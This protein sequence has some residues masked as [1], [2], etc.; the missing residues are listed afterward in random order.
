MVETTDVHFQVPY[1]VPS[2]QEVASEIGQDVQTPQF[3]AEQQQQNVVLSTVVDPLVDDDAEQQSAQ[4]GDRQRNDD[5]DD[6]VHEV[7]TQMRRGFS[8]FLGYRRT[9]SDPELSRPPD[10]CGDEYCAVLDA[11]PEHDSGVNECAARD[12][13]SPRW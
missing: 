1:S 8:R 9:S 7:C 12:V 4:G 10:D 13:A 6:D 11:R 3:D 5:G 2:L